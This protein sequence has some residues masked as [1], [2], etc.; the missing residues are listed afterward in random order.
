[1]SKE[2][3]VICGPSCMHILL[4]LFGLK[5]NDCYSFGIA[6]NYNYFN[7]FKNNNTFCIQNHNY[8]TAIMF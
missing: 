2:S 5:Q 7:T 6:T 4:W 8:T 3:K 1:M